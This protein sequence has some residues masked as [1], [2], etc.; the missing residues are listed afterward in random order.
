MMDLDKLAGVRGCQE[1]IQAQRVRD[2]APVL[3]EALEDAKYELMQCFQRIEDEFG[4]G[5]LVD[6]NYD[7]DLLQKVLTAIKQ[8]RGE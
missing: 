7:N 8:A 6:E 2:A 3:L 1:Y 5:G 4:A